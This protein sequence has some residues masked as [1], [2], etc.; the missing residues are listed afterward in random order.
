[1]GE[2]LQTHCLLG[3]LSEEI[4]CKKITIVLLQLLQKHKQQKYSHDRMHLDDD[5]M[6]ILYNWLKTHDAFKGLSQYRYRIKQVQN[7]QWTGKGGRAAVVRAGQCGHEGQHLQLSP[8]DN[9]AGNSVQLC[10]STWT[11]CS[12]DET[13]NTAPKSSKLPPPPPAL[14]R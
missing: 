2:L 5:R 12:L 4:V 7:V 14:K 10:R 9:C 3:M 13:L 6:S 8:A 11:C 1:M